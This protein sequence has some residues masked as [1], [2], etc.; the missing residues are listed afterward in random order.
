MTKEG[1]MSRR[2]MTVSIL[3][4][5]A[6]L[7]IAG[8]S[9]VWTFPLETTTQRGAIP[10]SMC[11]GNRGKVKEPIPIY[12]PE[13]PCPTP[14]KKDRCEGSVVLYMVVSAKGRVTKVGIVRA[15]G[16]GFDENAVKTV[17]TWRFRPATLD[18]RP[19]PVSGDLEVHFGSPNK[20]PQ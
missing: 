19:V 3:A 13:P 2:P 17:R 7:L 14:V 9:V 8:A 18:G 20:N 6:V 16:T 12:Y 5:G 11:W 4:A 10:P 15:L 1:H